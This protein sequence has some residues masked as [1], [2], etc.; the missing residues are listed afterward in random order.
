MKTAAFAAGA[1]LALGLLLLRMG[2]H[3]PDRQSKKP[4]I[5]P[6]RAAMAIG[7]GSMAGLVTG[8]PVGAVA[9]GAFVLA[10]PALLG[11]KKAAQR[12]IARTEAVAAWT[13][14]L[15]DTLAGAAG[16]HR[17]IL[18]TA[19]VAPGPIATEVH[20]LS[21][22]LHGRQPLPQALRAFAEDLADATADL[23][24]STLVL[25]YE[26][27]AGNLSALLGAL[28]RSARDEA[29]MQRR[30]LADRAR[31][32]AAE[33]VVTVFTLGAFGVLVVFNRSFLRAYDTAGGQLVLAVVVTMFGLGFWALHQ[34][35][36]LPTTERVLTAAPPP[37]PALADGSP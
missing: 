4:R 13:E 32:R 6:R 26:R 1:G 21:A 9:V 10:A 25:A 33:A 18:A 29:A 2:L 27:R 11:G 8:W 24:V 34:L 19:D 23:V 28:A 36:R 30:I 22:R 3:R 16:L 5:D 17:A 12:A 14:T 37:V 15:R 35:A 7:V 20:A 31:I